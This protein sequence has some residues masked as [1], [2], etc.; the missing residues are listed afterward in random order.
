MT[1]GAKAPALSLALHEE[2]EV[3]AG[4]RQALANANRLQDITMENA[5]LGL[6]GNAALA[7]ALAQAK[8]EGLTPMIY[9]H[10]IGY[11]GHGA[12]PPIGMT[13]YQTGVPVNGSPSASLP[14]TS[15]SRSG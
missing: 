13:D 15:R 14:S 6:T 2:S 9:C 11:H 7:A 1:R 4:L 5:K 12:G 8:A 3:G 10:P